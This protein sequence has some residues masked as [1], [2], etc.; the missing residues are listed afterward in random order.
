M[1]SKWLLRL[2]VEV[3]AGV[4]RWWIRRRD[5][6]RDRRGRRGK[7]VLDLNTGGTASPT[8]G[9]HGDNRRNM[10][11]KQPCVP[12]RPRIIGDGRPPGEVECRAHKKNGSGRP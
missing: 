9:Q 11:G 1:S 2:L 4:A 5:R 12:P 6:R 8:G 7:K 10:G 3:V